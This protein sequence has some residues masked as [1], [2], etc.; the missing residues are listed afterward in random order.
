MYDWQ[1][2]ETSARPKHR[3]ERMSFFLPW[4]FRPS[5]PESRVGSEKDIETRGANLKGITPPSG[6]DSSH[7]DNLG[8]L[9][10][11]PRGG[12]SDG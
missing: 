2:E 11:P 1:S 8:L 4:S 9:L 3:P 7:L 10:F 12:V 5:D 6:F